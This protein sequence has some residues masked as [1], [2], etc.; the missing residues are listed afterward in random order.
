MDASGE[1]TSSFTESFKESQQDLVRRYV[2]LLDATRRQRSWSNITATVLDNRPRGTS[3]LGSQEALVRSAGPAGT[4]ASTGDIHRLDDAF[5]MIV[6]TVRALC[7]LAGF[8][9]VII[10]RVA[11]L[12]LV[13]LL[14]HHVVESAAAE[15]KNL[16]ER[17][18]KVAV[19]G[20]VDYRIQQTIAIAEPEEEA[21]DEGGNRIGIAEK[22]PYQRQHEER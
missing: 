5:V 19:Q 2:K 4:G 17:L 13:K 10:D 9:L 8:N 22:R 12:A 21:R 15:V 14:A 18:A 7:T 3:L 16:A 20:G 11:V 6:E 1:K